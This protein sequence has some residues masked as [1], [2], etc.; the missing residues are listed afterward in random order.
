MRRGQDRFVVGD[1]VR[2]LL[3]PTADGHLG[4]ARLGDALAELA[5]RLEQETGVSSPISFPLSVDDEPGHGRRA[6][7]RVFH[8]KGRINI[9]DGRFYSGNR[10]DVDSAYRAIRRHLEKHHGKPDKELTGVLKFLFD[11]PAAAP[12]RTSIC[13]YKDDAGENVLEVST[14]LKDGE[15]LPGIGARLAASKR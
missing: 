8:Q 15:R 4:G 3:F 2:D 13:R 11:V 7:L 14:R 5:D 6:E 9:L 10:M 12:A 1:T